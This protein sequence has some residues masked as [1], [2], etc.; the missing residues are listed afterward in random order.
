MGMASFS[1]I[2]DGAASFLLTQ[3]PSDAK[4]QRRNCREGDREKGRE[5]KCLSPPLLFSPSP[6][7]P[8]SFSPL[9]PLSLSPFLFVLRLRQQP[10]LAHPLLA[11]LRPGRTGIS[12]VAEAETMAAG[13]VDVEFG[14]DRRTWQR[15]GASGAL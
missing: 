8:L 5:R 15:L 4:S 6:S 13:F 12:S 3:K 14:I 1:F 10:A 11:A 2:V 7:L 9:L